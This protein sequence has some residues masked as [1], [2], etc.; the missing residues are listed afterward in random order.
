ILDTGNPGEAAVARTVQDE[1][2]SNK[3]QRRKLEPRDKPYWRSLD[4]GLHLGYR[5]LRDKAGPWIVRLYLGNQNYE[6]QSIAT[7]DD[8][9]DS[10][11]A[12]VLD[13]SQAQTAAR[14]I[15]DGRSKTEVGLSGA[16]TVARCLSDYFNFLR[17]E[18]R[19]DYSVD[20]SEQ[21]AEAL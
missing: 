13:F 21:R 10:N 20:E 19:A 2:L 4:P 6:T 5:R 8:Y 15:R 18:G 9:S 17:S 16:Y 1:N 14:E 3:T 12:D 11:G 7:A